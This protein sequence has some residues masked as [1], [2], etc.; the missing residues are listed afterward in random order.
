MWYPT[1]H[2][3]NHMNHIILSC[4]SNSWYDNPIITYDRLNQ[5][6]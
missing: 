3:M 1:D 6:N 4:N 2:Q 5:P